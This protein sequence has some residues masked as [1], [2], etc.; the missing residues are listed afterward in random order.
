MPK[1]RRVNSGG[2]SNTESESILEAGI[3]DS[4]RKKVDELLTDED[5]DSSDDDNTIDD[6]Y[7]SDHSITLEDIKKVDKVL[8]GIYGIP[9][10]ENLTKLLLKG[11]LQP[12]HIS[13]QSVAYQVVRYTRGVSGVRYQDSYGMFWAAIRNLI[14]S[15][16]LVPFMDHFMIPSALS[17]YKKKLLQIGG[18]SADRLGKLGIQEENI[19]SWTSALV[20]EMNCEKLCLSISMDGKK[21]HMSNDGVEDMGDEDSVDKS[22]MGE[23][24]MLLNLLKQGSRGALFKAYDHL[25]TLC[26]TISS[27][28]EAIERLLVKNKTAAEKN[29]LLSKYVYVLNEQIGKGADLIDKIGHQQLSVLKLICS[30]RNTTHLIPHM[31]HV[32]LNMQANVRKL[33]DM[34]DVEDQE[35]VNRINSL[36][37]EKLTTFLW[38]DCNLSRPFSKVHPASNSYAYLEQKCILSSDEIFLASGLGKSSPVQDMKKIYMRNNSQF[39][40]EISWRRNAP[41]NVEATLSSLIAPMI[42][43]NNCY[44]AEAGIFIRN[45]FCSKP[46]FL[47]YDN[48]D[49]IKYVV[50]VVNKQMNPFVVD[51]ETVAMCVMDADLADSLSGSLLIQF[52]ENYCVAFSVSASK[53]ISEEMISIVKMYVTAPTVMNKRPREIILRVNSLRSK[54]QQHLQSCSI[55]GSFPLVTNVTMSKQCHSDVGNFFKSSTA[56]RSS[57]IVEVNKARIDGEI[58]IIMQE[59]T[60]FMSKKARELIVIN[61]SEMSGIGSKALPHTQLC[62]SFLTSSSLRVVGK[63]C[64]DKTIS[65][66]NECNAEVLNIGVDGES[67]HLATKLPNGRPGTTLALAKHIMS[68]LKSTNKE[69]IVNKM[70]RVKNLRVEL[71]LDEE[72]GDEDDR[73]AEVEADIPLTEEIMDEYIANECSKLEES[74]YDVSID[75]IDEWLSE[76]AVMVQDEVRVR[77][78]KSMNVGQ[79][80][81]LC[82][83]HVYPLAKKYWL[84]RSIGRENLLIKFSDG[85]SAKYIPNSIFD[86]TQSGYFRTIT[87]DMAHLR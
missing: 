87:F 73:V 64:L 44:I 20:N 86:K 24:D 27:R 52:S 51:L 45:G 75:D 55:L 36:S 2:P 79:L 78:L 70:S 31:E 21:I 13:V 83:T 80:R 56:E 19:K 22:G 77:K 48:S 8:E 7:L 67:L 1:L 29:P 84:S 53:L 5:Y 25:T 30:L 49:T 50:R 72:D 33:Q 39:D 35:N 3:L 69:F 42:F 6:K 34:T 11:M 62:S 10:I 15:S 60:D 68:L 47:I 41:R 14:K 26:E 66:I 12:T 63:Q 59:M 4:R 54:L 43:G 17:K 23:E 82:L 81:L 46:S 65:F 38:S 57:V 40:H 37:M 76:D 58:K 74:D 16:G 71:D 28:V 85:S 18:L 9:I 61:V 32:D